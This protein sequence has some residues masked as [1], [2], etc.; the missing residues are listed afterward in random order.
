MIRVLLVLAVM[1][2]SALSATVYRAPEAVESAEYIGTDNGP[3]VQFNLIAL[4]TVESSVDGL[5][6]GV[7]FR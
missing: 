3:V 2:A 5:G 1:S 6:S 4:E 7:V